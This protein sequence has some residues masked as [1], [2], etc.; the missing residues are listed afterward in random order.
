MT[1]ASIE[2]YLLLAV[3]LAIAGGVAGFLAGI[4]G[5]GGGTVVVP[6]LLECFAILGVESSVRAH[7]AIGTSL[8]IIVPT[9]IRSYLAHRAKGAPDEALLWSWVVAVPLGVVVASLV[10]AGISGNTLKWLFAVIAALMALNMLWG[11][12]GWQLGAEL[13]KGPARQAAGFGIGIVSTFMGIGGG[14]LNNLFMTAY[15]RTLHQAVA[16]SA[17]LGLLIALPGALGYVWAGWGRADL[18]PASAGYVNLLALTLMT[19]MALVTAPWGA[20]FTHS[21]DRRQLEV[22]F[23][24]FL[25]LVAARLA[26]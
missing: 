15:G 7:A 5:V 16:T 9:A 10:V 1:A 18:A 24:A 19:P 3:A 22:A 14:I 12:D 26:S 4:F 13:P 8:A 21:L 20:R 17:G 23:G 25:L 11:S 6:I 2:A